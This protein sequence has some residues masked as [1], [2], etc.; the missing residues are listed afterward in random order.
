MPVH[1]PL[2]PEKL[3]P[4]AGVVDNVTL[5]PSLKFDA[6]VVGQSIPAGLLVTVP[7]PTTET[8]NWAGPMAANVAETALL[9]ESSSLHAEPLH[10][11]LKPPK[12]KPDPAVAVN[13][14]DAPEAKL[15]VQTEG[16]LIPAGLLTTVPLPV[17]ETVNCTCCCSGC[18]VLEPPPQALNPNSRRRI[19][20]QSG[21]KPHTKGRHLS[22]RFSWSARVAH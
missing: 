13:V 14:A 6:Q 11:P 17:T 2:N 19:A 7:L 22:P 21:D 16:Q 5:V 3:Y 8:V 9:L 10:A 4:A 20:G 12:L 18:G 15:W 1:A